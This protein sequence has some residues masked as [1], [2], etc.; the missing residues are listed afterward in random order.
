[1]TEFEEKLVIDNLSLVDTVIRAR[2][3]CRPASVLMTYEDLQAVGRA[4]LCRAATRYRPELGQFTTFAGRCIANALIDHCRREAGHDRAAAD[5]SDEDRKEAVM[6]S[7]CVVDEEDATLGALA[8][9][10]V[11]DE[12]KRQYSGVARLGV[13]AVELKLLGFSSAEIAKRYDTSVNNVNAWIS[14]LRSKLRKD[15]RNPGLTL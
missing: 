4:A 11:L 12:L 14:R 9:E 15:G 13:E 7:A 3:H 10:T 6:E 2:F 8:V 1:M 5:I